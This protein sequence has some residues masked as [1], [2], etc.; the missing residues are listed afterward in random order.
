MADW[1]AQMPTI[2]QLADVAASGRAG[3][4]PRMAAQPGVDQVRVR[5]AVAAALQERQVLGVL[6]RR[7]LREPADRLRQQ[8]GVVGH[9]HPLRNLRLR[10]PL[11]VDHRV[12]ALDLL[13]L[14][15]L[16]AAG[17]VEALAVLPGRVEQAARHL[18]DHVGIADLERRRLDGER[19]VVAADQLLADAARAVADDALGVLAQ[20]AP[21]TG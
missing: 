5:A 12:F 4:S 2:V 8:A 14:E 21:G 16:L 11:G 20:R 10:Q 13:P 6:D 17:D 7:R 9:L 19:A 3:R 18:G 15:A 1:W